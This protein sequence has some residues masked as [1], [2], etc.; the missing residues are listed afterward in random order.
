[1]KKGLIVTLVLLGVVSIGALGFVSRGFINWNTSEWADSVID[2]FNPGSTSTSTSNSTEASEIS[3]IE[4]SESI[5]DSASSP[6]IDSITSEDPSTLL[7]PEIYYV[8][9]PSEYIFTST[10]VTG[11]TSGYKEQHVTVN[12][13]VN[14]L[15]NMPW[16]VCIGQMYSSVFSM[17]WTSTTT[18]NLY[19]NIDVVNNVIT[20]SEKYV[21][22]ASEFYLYQ[23]SSSLF[24]FSFN[25]GSLDATTYKFFIL[26]K[27]YNATS[28][29]FVH[30]PTS[31]ELTSGRES[32]N[33][34]EYSANLANGY[35]QFAFGFISSNTTAKL[36]SPVI[37]IN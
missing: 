5:I 33:P 6:S 30:S 16:H 37:S 3:S 13:T 10:N 35:Y 12:D 17:G 18:A 23:D 14:S 31:G 34:I 1:M 29:S 8:R 11:A 26:Q 7:V 25:Y 19:M 32:D 2:I 28:W 22:L 20:S 27:E 24:H 21:Y 15:T 4:D 36:S 9:S